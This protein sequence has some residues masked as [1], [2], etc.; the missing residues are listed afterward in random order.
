[1][2]TKLTDSMLSIPKPTQSA[3][4]T[5]VFY[6]ANQH[7]LSYKMPYFTF[8]NSIYTFKNLSQ[9]ATHKLTD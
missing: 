7:V 5:S 3:I 9:H 2:T 1:M 6:S 8:G 4:K